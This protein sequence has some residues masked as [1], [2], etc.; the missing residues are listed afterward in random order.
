M[1]IGGDDYRRSEC[2][3]FGSARLCRKGR[4]TIATACDSSYEPYRA[5][6][7]PVARSSMGEGVGATGCASGLAVFPSDE[8]SEMKQIKLDLD[9]YD[10]EVTCNNQPRNT[11]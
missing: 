10:T 8:E 7:H 4:A 2:G 9:S 5:A 1:S 6:G 11:E 3:C